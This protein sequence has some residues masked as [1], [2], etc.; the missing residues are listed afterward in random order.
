MSVFHPDRLPAPADARDGA[1][2]L[3]QS[4]E[5]R[6]TPMRDVEA[7]EEALRS[8]GAKVRLRRYDGWH[9]DLWTMIAEGITWMD[10]QAGSR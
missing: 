1:F 8:A 2:Y 7:A 6:I 4:P 3:L 5:D 10:G 9:G